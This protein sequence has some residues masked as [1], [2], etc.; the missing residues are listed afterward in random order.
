[1]CINFSKNVNSFLRCAN[2][3]KSEIRCTSK[4]LT[5]MEIIW[6]VLFM[7]VFKIYSN[8]Y[9]KSFAGDNLQV[10][11]LHRPFK[12][13]VLAHY[14]ESVPWNSFDKDAVGMVGK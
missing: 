14:P 3:R 2:V 1:M 12:S 11:P 13:K 8:I 4:F 7:L 5:E 10:S 6:G 9:F